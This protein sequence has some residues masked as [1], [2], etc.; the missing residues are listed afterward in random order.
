MALHAYPVG[1]RREV[2][3][4]ESLDKS[5]TLYKLTGGGVVV[6]SRSRLTGEISF[7]NPS[8]SIALLLLKS[9]DSGKQTVLI[10]YVIHLR[11]EG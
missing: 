8:I 10:L 3:P 9:T 2:K 7:S 5:L 4:E 11:R 1:P 6:V